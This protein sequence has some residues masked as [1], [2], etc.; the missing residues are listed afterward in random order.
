[1]RQSGPGQ[2]PLL[3]VEGFDQGCQIGKIFFGGW[4]RGG[5]F[6]HAKIAC[7][8]SVYYYLKKSFTEAFRKSISSGV[9]A[10]KK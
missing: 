1:M 6:L 10:S 4:G 8:K 5:F 9:L 2:S 3:S 7:S